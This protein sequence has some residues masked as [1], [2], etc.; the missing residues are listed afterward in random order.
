MKYCELLGG[1]GME[2]NQNPEIDRFVR[3]RVMGVGGGGG[4]AVTRM[5]DMGLRGVDFYIVNTDAQALCSSK[6][7][8]KIQLGPKTTGGLGAGANPSIGLSAAKESQHEIEQALEG[9][10]MVF[11][12]VGMGGGTGTGSAPIVADVARELGALTVAVVTKPFSFE[13]KHRRTTAE[14]G[15]AVLKG[16]VDTLIV[17]PNDQL[18]KVADP[19]LALKDAFKMADEILRQGVQG[20]SDLITINGLIN[21]DF[22][23]IKTIMTRAGSALIGIGEGKG[24]HRAI[25]AAEN[26]INSPLLD[27]P[28]KGA[29]GILLNITGG[30]DMTLHE[31]NAAAEIVSNEA[32][33]NANII[34]GSVVDETIEGVI[35]VTVLA[36]GFGEAAT[37]TIPKAETGTKTYNIQPQEQQKKKA[38]VNDP[39]IPSFFR[40]RSARQD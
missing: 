21:L 2:T 12:T 4:N 9:S 27:T 39:D 10:D 3:I 24:E 6:V 34:F 23:D 18:L 37:S 8:H 31:V 7:R 38:A 26:A 16:K 17:I 35:R 20:I 28:I 5:I 33:E 30:R 40:P 19:K 14:E 36:T 32:H 29:Q 11:I 1:G 15:I 22:A 25:E 13:G